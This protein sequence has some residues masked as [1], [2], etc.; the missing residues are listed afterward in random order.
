MKSNFTLSQDNKNLILTLPLLQDSYDAADELIGQ[1][2]NLVGVIA[3]QEFSISQLI[4]L[5]YKDD[6]Q[7]G[8]PI[9]MFNDREQ[10]EEICKIFDLDIWEHPLCAYCERV[11]RGTFTMSYKGNMCFDCQ[12][13][14][15]LW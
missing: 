11:I 12:L 4:D 2:P 5:G 10:L 13:K 3:G 9:I 14:K 7:E 8:M 15:K 6:I 1:V